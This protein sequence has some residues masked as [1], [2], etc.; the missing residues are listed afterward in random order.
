MNM[1]ERSFYLTSGEILYILQT[2][3][4]LTG[5]DLLEIQQI[6]C[7]GE[8][9]LLYKDTNIITRYST[10]MVL[11]FTSLLHLRIISRNNMS[12]LTETPEFCILRYY[13]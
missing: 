6:K 12:T 13:S 5:A 2:E 8:Y 9:T 7:E 11:T 4:R 3:I 10:S 1:M